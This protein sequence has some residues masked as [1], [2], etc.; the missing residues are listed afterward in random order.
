MLLFAAST[1]L[2]GDRVIVYGFVDQDPAWGEPWPS[3]LRGFDAVN[4][5]MHPRQC[6]PERD[7]YDFS[8]LDTQ[9]KL[10]KEKNIKL[11]V[12]MVPQGEDQWAVFWPDWWKETYAH[13]EFPGKSRLWA[14][15]SP[16]MSAD[17]Q[18][19]ISA[20]AAYCATRAP[21][22]IA[23]RMPIAQ[24]GEPAITPH[25]V[26]DGIALGYTPDA[27]LKHLQGCY[28]A[29]TKA[30]P[31]L[32]R[33][34]CVNS[35]SLPH[36]DWSVFL[37]TVYLSCSA[38]WFVGMY[39]FMEEQD[40]RADPWWNAAWFNEGSLAHEPKLASWSYMVSLANLN[41]LGFAW[42]NHPE[43]IRSVGEQW[44]T[45]MYMDQLTAGRNCRVYSIVR[46]IDKNWQQYV[47]PTFQIWAAKWKAA[48]AG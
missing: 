31:T 21:T 26:S 37:Q 6:W 1:S 40:Y 10:A 45:W 43:T 15:W 30:A 20:W 17:W 8:W 4:V 29:V 23:L 24:W 3:D 19:F 2:A 38:D 39:S 7:K 16:A 12:V 46:A 47:R 44:S 5:N 48:N 28:E 11:L 35:P 34:V 36:I 14:W 27:W 22:V 32:D 9:V 33:I 41:G 18:K 13:L 25:H 42:E